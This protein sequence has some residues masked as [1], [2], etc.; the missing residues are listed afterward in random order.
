MA[1]LERACV[2]YWPF[3]NHFM[4]IR[5]LENIGE[6][7]LHAPISSLLYNANS[8]IVMST[9]Q[10]SICAIQINVFG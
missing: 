4:L 5:C 6:G 8:Y 3:P 9:M 2:Q 10:K 7:L 1:T